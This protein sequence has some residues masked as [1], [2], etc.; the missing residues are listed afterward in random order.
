MPSAFQTTCGEVA[1]RRGMLPD[2]C[3]PS[4]PQEAARAPPKSAAATVSPSCATMATPRVLRARRID[5]A[6][7]EQ[8]DGLH[9]GLGRQRHGLDE[10]RDLGAVEGIISHGRLEIAQSLE[11]RLGVGHALQERVEFGSIDEVRGVRRGQHRC[12][13][14][15]AQTSAIILKSSCLQAR[16]KTSDGSAS[17]ASCSHNRAHLAAITEPLHP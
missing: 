11:V 13:S 2:C 15:D 8:D 7:A 12:P 1:P 3:V 10:P 5:D 14:A 16:S 6:R 4:T 9:G 17:S